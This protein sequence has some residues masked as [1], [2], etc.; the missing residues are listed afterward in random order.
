MTHD[1]VAGML[2]GML[3]G[4]HVQTSSAIS[5]LGFFLAKHPHIQVCLKLSFVTRMKWCSKS[6]NATLSLRHL[7]ALQTFFG[8]A[9][10]A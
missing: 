8:W 3:V 7:G 4:G 6:D 10:K 9:K 5:W 2:I 1:E